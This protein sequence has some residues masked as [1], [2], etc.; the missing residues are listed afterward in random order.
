ML[1]KEGQRQ[2]VD[3]PLPNDSEKDQ[4]AVMRDLLECDTLD[5]VMLPHN[6]IMWVDDEG[7][8][9]ANNTIHT[10]AYVSDNQVA[11]MNDIAGNILLT[12]VDAKSATVG[13]DKETADMVYRNF[14]VIN[15]KTNSA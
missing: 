1:I 6:V 8:F 12:S 10:V 14:R 3:F 4:L 9:N 2:F 13:F 5:A 7:L 15:T 11:Y